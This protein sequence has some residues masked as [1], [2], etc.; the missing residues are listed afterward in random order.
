MGRKAESRGSSVGQLNREEAFLLLSMLTLISGIVVGFAL[1]LTGGGGSIFA[2]PLLIYLLHVDVRTAVGVSLAVVGGTSLFGV[3]TRLR[4]GEVDFKVGGAFAI[5]GMVGAPVGTWINSLLPPTVVL[6]AFG[7]LMLVVGLRMWKRPTESKG[8]THD[9]T[10]QIAGWQS[11]LRIGLIGFM[12]GVITGIF[13]VGG[14][15]II[16]PAL[17]LFGG[18][19]V[20]RAVST[21]LM[22]ITLICLSGVTSYLAGGETMPVELTSLFVLG[23]CL[24]MM[25]GGFL[26]ARLSGNTMRRVFAAAM[27]F[28]ALFI[29]TKTILESHDTNQLEAVS[30]PEQ[31][32]QP[33][34]EVVATS[35]KFEEAIQCFG[36]RE[37]L[38]KT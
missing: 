25:S 19:T 34:V 9:S 16:V 11:W 24:G 15:F 4:S 7:I 22:V 26:R 8:A 17:V 30:G 28:L 10:R 12:V 31:T 33:T 3:L 21:S 27:W 35:L 20:H 13:G 6:M 38:A 5:T 23:G 18:V 32:S 29:L 36:E 37:F 14:G 2:V 1:G